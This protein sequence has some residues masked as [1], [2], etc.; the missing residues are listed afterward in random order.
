[1]ID[2]YEKFEERYILAPTSADLTLKLRYS[3]LHGFVKGIAEMQNVIEGE[4]KAYN[5]N[6]RECD[7][8]YNLSKLNT[9]YKYV[10][11]PCM[12]YDFIFSFESTYVFSKIKNTKFI[13]AEYMNLREKWMDEIGKSFVLGMPGMATYLFPPKYPINLGTF[14]VDNIGMDLHVYIAAAIGEIDGAEYIVQYL[15]EKIEDS[16]VNL[17]EIRTIIRKLKAELFPLVIETYNESINNYADKCKDEYIRDID[18]AKIYKL[19][20]NSQRYSEYVKIAVDV[21]V[22]NPD[23][24]VNI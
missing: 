23:I 21:Y 2:F 17:K 16:S 7:F 11:M 10:L 20:R 4:A 14:N 22:R 6:N 18:C 1:M 8:H 5:E 3:Y 13:Y 15:T 9:R 19:T 24:I 12:L